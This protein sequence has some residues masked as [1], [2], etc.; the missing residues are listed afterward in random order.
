[1]DK[2]VGESL[3]E[4][5]KLRPTEFKRE[6]RC[7]R[8]RERERIVGKERGGGGAPKAPFNRGGG[9]WREEIGR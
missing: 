6:M 1:M 7:D 3:S 8:V 2:V 5:S 4:R 9:G